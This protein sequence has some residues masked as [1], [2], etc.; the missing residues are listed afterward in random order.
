MTKALRIRHG[1]FGRVAVLEMDRRL[2]VHAHP[3]AHLVFKVAGADGCF[4]LHDR[5]LPLS[6]EWAIAVN[7]WEPHCF[8]K[9]GDDPSSRILAL[10]LNPSWLVAR[11]DDFPGRQCFPCHGVRVSPRLRTL[12]DTPN[13]EMIYGG[14][15][16]R[17]FVEELLV[18]LAD[19]VRQAPV[20]TAERKSESFVRVAPIDRRIRRSIELMHSRIGERLGFETLARSVGLSRQ[21]F[22]DLFRRTTAL[23]PSVYRNTLR[24][25]QAVC[26]L[27]AG[28]R[29][30]HDIAADL[31][32]S[33]QSNFARFFRD[34]KGLS[35][36][37]YRNAVVAMDDPTPPGRMERG[38]VSVFG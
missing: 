32:F 17:A 8:P 2:V 37:A 5:K 20:A 23:T 9:A 35:P 10:Q 22:F 7:P 14:G 36:R 29:P 15:E 31:G 3:H 27:G 13:A 24:M 28:L 38:P 16:D 19:R 11:L 34:H 4:G 18:T 12:V 25:E 6:T 26:E 33:A 30:I 1:S 21:H